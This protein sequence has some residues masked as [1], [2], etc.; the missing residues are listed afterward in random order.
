M[1]A[2]VVHS[3][4]YVNTIMGQLISKGDRVKGGIIAQ[5]CKAEARDKEGCKLNTL[6]LFRAFQISCFRG[7]SF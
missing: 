4:I 5:F 2:N 6:A 3:S 7:E 1:D